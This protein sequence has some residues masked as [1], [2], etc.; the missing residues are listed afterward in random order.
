V[1]AASGDP[2]TPLSAA[3]RAVE[4]L[5]AAHLLVIRAEQHLVYPYAVAAPETPTHRC[6]LGAVESYLIDGL[7]PPV[8]RCP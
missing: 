5:A 3:R 1:L 8:G 7:T 4:D 6:V 2:T